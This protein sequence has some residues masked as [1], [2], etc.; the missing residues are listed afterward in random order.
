MNRRVETNHK[1][2]GVDSFTAP[3]HRNYIV[4]VGVSCCSG[5][6]GSI[7]GELLPSRAVSTGRMHPSRRDPRI[8]A[9]SRAARTILLFS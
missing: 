1:V 5:Q 4:V 7:G 6:R 8:L 2:K 9:L 3:S